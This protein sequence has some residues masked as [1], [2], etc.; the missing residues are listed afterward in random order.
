MSK[1][2][3]TEFARLMKNKLFYF[4]MLIMFVLPIFCVV[5]QYMEMKEY[6]E[7]FAELGSD[8]LSADDFLFIGGFYGIIVAAV[9]LGYFIGTD[10]SYGTIR[11][12][13]IAGH[14]RVHIYLSN[15]IVCGAATMIL[16]LIFIITILIVGGILFGINAPVQEMLLLIAVE[17]L[18]L[19]CVAALYL[20]IVVVW[21][22]RSAGLA[23]AILI[24]FL[25]I[26]AA[27]T[28]DNRLSAPEYYPDIVVDGN[29]GELVELPPEKNRYY[30]TGTK[31]KVYEALYDILPSC[32]LY[33][34]VRSDGL[35]EDV[36]EYVILMA[37]SVVETAGLSGIGIFIF[38]RKDLK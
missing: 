13:L 11:N 6:P 24:G 33:R 25:M 26:M 27:M 35:S 1:L 30:I 12:K 14:K 29:T 2:L 19:I 28:I 31:R 20:L 10:Y 15:F 38:S 34:L 23:S 36:A 4:A 18:A 32:Q 22:S 3:R 17:T 37:L 7:V 8:Y 16:N 21:A 5:Q 9:L